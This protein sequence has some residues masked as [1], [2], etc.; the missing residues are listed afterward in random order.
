MS[1]VLSSLLYRDSLRVPVLYKYLYR[2]YYTIYGLRRS[3]TT[4]TTRYSTVAARSTTGRD[5]SD[6]TTANSG[7]AV[8]LFL[9]TWKVRDS[10]LRIFLPRGSPGRRRR[11]LLENLPRVLSN[12]NPGP[13]WCGTEVLVS[14]VASN[15]TRLLGS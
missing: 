2:R 9:A 1:S 8:V 10:L 13:C 6:Y 4:T 15:A 11:R 12:P 7:L 3:P 5:L 14:Y